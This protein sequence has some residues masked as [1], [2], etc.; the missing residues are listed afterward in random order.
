[1]D[2]A[3]GLYVGSHHT[4]AYVNARRASGVGRA[5]LELTGY[6]NALRIGKE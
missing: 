4:S 6:A 1:M 3:D 2:L 5:Y